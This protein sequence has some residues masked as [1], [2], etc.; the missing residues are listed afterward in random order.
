MDGLYNKHGR[1]NTLP[2]QKTFQTVLGSRVSPISCKTFQLNWPYC[3][4]NLIALFNF[5]TNYRSMFNLVY[6][7]F[8]IWWCSCHTIPISCLILHG[9][10]TQT[11]L[12]WWKITQ[13]VQLLTE[14]LTVNRDVNYTKTDY[15]LNYILIYCLVCHSAQHP[16]RCLCNNLHIWHTTTRHD[17]FLRK[18]RR[19]KSFFNIE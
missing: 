15:F 7:V 12:M 3:S 14:T 19:Q 10:G 8:H 11:L 1:L 2:P 16:C 6:K 17:E 18:T 4:K 5:C 13:H 9:W